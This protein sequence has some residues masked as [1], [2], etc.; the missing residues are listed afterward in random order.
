MSKDVVTLETFAAGLSNRYLKCRELGHIWQPFTVSR[1]GTGFLRRLRCSS[2][3]TIREQLLDS[4][5]HVIRNGYKY[6]DGYLA[7]DHVE[8]GNY[9]RDVF[10]LESVIRFIDKG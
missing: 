6:A 10:R 7:K 1:E 3:K 8:R 5:G 9:S 4:R 2:C